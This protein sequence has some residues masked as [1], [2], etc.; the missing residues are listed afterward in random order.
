M[1]PIQGL[2][3]QSR[4]ISLSSCLAFVVWRCKLT[5]VP[6]PPVE[7][8]N[9]LLQVLQSGSRAIR[10]RQEISLGFLSSN[11]DILPSCR[12]ASDFLLRSGQLTSTSL[13]YSTS[14]GTRD[15]RFV[16]TQVQQP[17]TTLFSVE[18]GLLGWKNAAFD[19]GA[20]RF[21]A[22]P[23]QPLLVLF[24]GPLPEGYSNVMLRTVAS[25]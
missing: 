13:S 3:S 4:L 24:S 17:I 8:Q 10:R 11:G 6:S 20:A 19:G 9:F 16:G 15:R 12:R 25:R 14:Q 5:G 22:Q 18:D 21:C 7:E 23:A 1:S 2:D